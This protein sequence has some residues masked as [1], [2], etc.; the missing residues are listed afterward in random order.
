MGRIEMTP[1][2]AAAVCEALDDLYKRADLITKAVPGREVV[3]FLAPAAFASKIHVGIR[4]DNIL[5]DER[6]I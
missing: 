5:T 1:R 2:K 6:W 4:E 3:V